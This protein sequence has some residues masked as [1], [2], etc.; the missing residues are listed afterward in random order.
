[1]ETRTER[2]SAL[3]IAMMSSF[4]T[5]F[6]ASSIVVALPTIGEEFS[7]STIAASW[8]ANAYLL[9][10]AAFLVPFGR[11]ADIRGR[12]WLFLNGMWVFSA[13]TAL[14]TVAPSVETLLAFRVM[15]GIGSAM[16][17]GTSIAI[18]TSVYPPN[19]RGKALGLTT[20]LVYIGLSAGPV[21]GGALTQYFSWRAIFVVVLPLCGAIMFVGYRWLLGEWRG[22]EGEKFDLVGSV[23]YGLSLTG[24]VLGL[25]F[26]PNLL[27]SAVMALGLVGIFIFARLEKR[28][29]C[30]VLDTKLFSQNRAFAFS[31]VAALINYSATFA[32]AFLMSFYLQVEKGFSANYAGLILVS[33]PILMAVFSP[34]AGRLSDYF[35]PQ[36]IA[37]IGMAITATGLVLLALLTTDSSLLVIV[38]S[39]ALLGF[40][41]A[42]FSSPNTNAIMTSVER[43]CYGIASATVGTMRLIGQTLSIA[44]ATLFISVY[45]GNVEV[46]DMPV[47]EFHDAFRTSFV[48]FAALCYIGVFASLARGKVHESS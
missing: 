13:A 27:A 19:E 2:R 5:P 47:T 18:I 30:P 38:A 36:Y 29:E 21:L 45:V 7:V 42:F 35:E 34:V 3:T 20:M 44:V 10:A 23:V 39:L 26:L 14:C 4:L 8:I 32:V 43:K 41:F 22:A 33:Q 25:T 31:N 1:L 17:F 24:V 6:L 16:I 37:S 48:V 12:K 11:I 9:A 15:Q 46:M 28:T 40:G